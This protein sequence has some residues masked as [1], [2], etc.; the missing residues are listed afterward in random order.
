[1]KVPTV[2]S[3]KDIKLERGRPLN[4]RFKLLKIDLGKLYTEENKYDIYIPDPW[5]IALKE[6]AN[7]SAFAYQDADSTRFMKLLPG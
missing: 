1:M 3:N 6:A 7:W 2:G 5:I 4:R